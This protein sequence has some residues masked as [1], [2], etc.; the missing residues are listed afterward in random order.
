MKSLAELIESAS[1]GYDES[2]ELLNQLA[3]VLNQDA[4]ECFSSQNCTPDSALVQVLASKDLQSEVLEQA[5]KDQDRIAEAIATCLSAGDLSF[6]LV[7]TF[8]DYAQDLFSELKYYEGM[9]RI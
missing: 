1:M 2:L 7:M 6:S 3:P 8:P 4:V 5:V 9:G